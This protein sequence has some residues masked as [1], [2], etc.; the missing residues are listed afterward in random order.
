MEFLSV[1]CSSLEKNST[2]TIPKKIHSIQITGRDRNPQGLPQKNP[3]G[4]STQHPAEAGSWP[5][6]AAA[7]QAS[8]WQLAINWPGGGRELAKSWSGVGWALAGNWP[9]TSWE[10][11]DQAGGSP[12]AGRNLAG[13]LPGATPEQSLSHEQS[14]MHQATRIP[15]QHLNINHQKSHI[16]NH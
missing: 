4:N 11:H 13:N 1:K 3:Q 12:G 2:W 9:K 6:G 15:P 8:D 5:A 16:A 7:G 10:R 14:S